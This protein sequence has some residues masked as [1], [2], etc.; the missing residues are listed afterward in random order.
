MRFPGDKLAGSSA[1]ALREAPSFGRGDQM[2]GTR[3][4]FVAR[5]PILNRRHK[6]VGYELLFRAAAGDAHADLRNADESTAQVIVDSL[7]T[8]G[9]DALIGPML[10]FLNTTPRFLESD[11]VEALP[12]ERVVLEIPAMEEVGP[13]FEGRCRELARKGY[14]LAL[15]GLARRDPREPLLAFAKF[16]KLDLRALGGAL[17]KPLARRIKRYPVTLVAEKVE[18]V[19]EF[20]ACREAGCD[21]FQG[22]YFAR[23]VTVVGQ[24]VDPDRSVLMELLMKVGGDGDF[25]ELV[26]VIKRNTSLTVNLLRLVNSGSLARSTRVKSVP[27]A[28]LLIGR[29]QLVRWLTVLLYAGE[30]Q[31]GMED[32]LLKVAAKRGRTM[33]LLCKQAA[34]SA[35]GPVDADM[36]YLVGMLSMMDVLFAAPMEQVLGQIQVDEAVREALVHRRGLVGGL[37]RVEERMERSAFEEVEGILAEI[38]LTP[39][40]YAL[41]QREAYAWVHGSDSPPFDV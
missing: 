8:I 39:D 21:L 20:A 17:V 35:E 16:A 32:A 40:Q 6:I 1:D 7:A 41:A 24:R 4:S 12:R 14:R 25:E 5:Q 22:Y 29:S 30:S 36:A 38:G 19:E 34:G 18:T 26:D 11:L 28:L 9:I 10:G 13:G 3:E 27:E 23:P 33:E 37:L 15:E 2:A 31:T